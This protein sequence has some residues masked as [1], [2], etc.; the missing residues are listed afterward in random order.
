M[1]AY[2]A[3][4]AS[5]I[6]MKTLISLTAA[7]FLFSNSALACFHFPNNYQGRL[8]EGTQEVFMFHDGSDAHMVIRTQLQAKKFPKEV[9]WVLP[10]PSL[11]SKYEEIKGIFFEE[12]K[13]LFPSEN[14]FGKGMDEGLGG[15]RGGSGHDGFK[16]H[17][18]VAL[19]NYTIQPI[20][21]LN[22]GAGN[23]FN[24]WLKKNKFNSMPLANQKY[25]LKKG[26]VFLAIRMNLNMPNPANLTS[27]PLHIIYKADKLAVP[28]KFTHDS[29]QFDLDLYVFSKKE[30]KKDLS[31]MYLKNE[32]KVAYE[33]KR[34]TPFLD[35]I[36][37]KH[38]GFI[39]RYEGKS[40]N[41]KG[42][43][44]KNLQNDPEFLITELN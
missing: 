34:E 26:A 3:P 8:Q 14:R 25:Y 10:F 28:M 24:A 19:E 39:T 21:I 30:L 16:V 44:I 23:E 29:R 15:S 37:G 5:L 40:L 13:G 6:N 33:N 1:F 36:I 42:Q 9:A 38:K 7:V 17:S 41:K 20:E 27:K 4:N 12:V 35:A 18:T 32:E 11:P 43:L 22:E 31:A 2:F